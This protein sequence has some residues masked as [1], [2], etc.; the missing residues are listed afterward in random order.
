VT[1]SPAPPI[2]VEGVTVRDRGRVACAGVTFAVPAGCIHVLLGAGPGPSALWRC[3]A[4]PVRP[5]AGRALV[6]GLDPARRWRLRGRRRV[7]AEGEDVRAAVSSRK[8]PDVLLIDRPDAA[9]IAAAGPRIRELAAA[10][11]A[12]LVAT[13]D[14]DV[15]AQ[16]AGR[17]GL[18]G[19][20]RLVAEGTVSDL[21]ARFRRLRYANRVTETR[22]AFGT[23]LDEFDA[24][25]VR[26][27]GWGIEA[28]VGNFT[29]DSFER[30]RAVDGVEEATAED[31]SLEEIL[32]ACTE[33]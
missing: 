5:E 29:A 19:R 18:F 25:R 8:A 15:A 28:V 9:A 6:L 30:L 2:L 20:G 3:L 1:G 26:V 12:T 23:E 24:V 16:I 21:R 33:T 13:D 22:T 11:T 17:I 14:A 10:G 31:M 27:R 32:E 4:G 7:V